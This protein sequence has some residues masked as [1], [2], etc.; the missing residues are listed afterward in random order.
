MDELQRL[1][2][3]EF[4]EASKRP[5]VLV[6]DN[7]RS[8]HNVGSVFRTA[9]AFRIERII[10]CGM[11]PQPPHRDITK[12]ALGAELAVPWQY[13][14]NI[15]DALSELKRDG[16]GLWAVEQAHGSTSLEQWKPEGKTALIFGHEVHGVSDEVLEQADGCL[17]IPQEG[18]KHSLNISVAVGVVL[19]EVVRE[20]D[21]IMRS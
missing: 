18:T 14:E 11:T 7:V 13:F 9:D 4:H 16:Y 17:E 10:L 5:V 2:P 21:E 12:T 6:L 15:S 3:R 8:M 19:W 1:Q 20:G